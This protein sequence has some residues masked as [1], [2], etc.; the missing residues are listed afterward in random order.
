MSS[1]FG[2]Q[3][4]WTLRNW[5]HSPCSTSGGSASVASSRPI[6]VNGAGALRLL[7]PTYENELYDLLYLNYPGDGAGGRFA[8]DPDDSNVDDG[9]DYIIPTSIVRPTTGTFVRTA[10]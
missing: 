7:T 6:G 8:Y 10:L 2:H 9:I 1:P 5:F 4:S 3:D